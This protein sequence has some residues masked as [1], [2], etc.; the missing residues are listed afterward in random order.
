MNWQ[1]NMPVQVV[2]GRGC[3]AREG[4]RLA[5]LGRRALLVTGRH[6]AIACGAQQDME[7]V[8]TG[9]G[10]SW[11]VF[12][13]VEPNPSIETVRK[14]AD[15]AKTEKAD[16]IIGIGG[17][18][19]LDAAKAIALL[20][21]NDLDDN[22]LFSGVWPSPPLPIAAIPTTSGTG[23]EVTP[24]A[25]L[26]DHREQAKRNLSAPSL[27]PRVSFC[28]GAYT[29]SLPSHITAHTAID[30]LSHA[31]EGYLSVKAHPMSDALARAAMASLGKDL[32]QLASLGEDASPPSLRD[33]LMI[34]SMQAGMV[35]AHTG[36]TALH[37]LGYALTI[38]RDID[39]GRAN[40]LL[41]GAYL[42]FVSQAAPARVAEA[43]AVMG[44]TDIDALEGVLTPLLGI[45]ETLS[46]EE[47]HRFA[48]ATS[49]ARNLPSTL[50]VPVLADL[51]DLYRTMA[52]GQTPYR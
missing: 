31:L 24:Y 47:I 10:I 39:H 30:A 35:I 20:A 26:T 25:I 37:A 13:E 49:S 11:L 50:R 36:T 6:S 48:Q 7:T 3:L 29:D 19:P 15:L 9:L 46:R 8:L 45:R 22:A 33:S 21:T 34:G 41:M 2:G 5:I 12:N 42:R 40:G 52:Q 16:F 18:S 28:D 1:F 44:F 43:L 51:E 17:G 27:F 32:R 14:A 38:H 4:A 23:S